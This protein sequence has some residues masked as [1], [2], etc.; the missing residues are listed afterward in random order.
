MTVE[1]IL[2]KWLEEKGYDGLMA[3]DCERGCEKSNLFSCGGP[4]GVPCG[5]C[6]PAYR[7]LSPIEGTRGWAMY[8]SKKAADV[9]IANKHKDA[10]VKAAKEW[11]PFYTGRYLDMAP[12][13]LDASGCRTREETYNK[14][15]AALARA[16]KAIQ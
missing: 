5:V 3:N 1:D 16:V 15:L 13:C 7:G 9:T 2:R 8:A 4:S 6:R 11:L 14:A 12:G 10:V